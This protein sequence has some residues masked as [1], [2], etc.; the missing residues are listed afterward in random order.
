[1]V[2]PD[3]TQDQ[4]SQSRFRLDFGSTYAITGNIEAYFD[5]KNLTDTLLEFT[6][7][8][9]QYYPVQR[10]FYGPS[11]FFGLRA[12]FGPGSFAMMNREDDD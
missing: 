5:V 7:S 10:E 3:V 9:S 6:Q 4:Y 8:R 1:V 2:G 12:Q 11:F